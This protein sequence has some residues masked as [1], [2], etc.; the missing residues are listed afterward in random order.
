MSR[1][2][3]VGSSAEQ[4]EQYVTQHVDLPGRAVAAVDLHGAVRFGM[5]SAGRPDFVGR[6]VGLQPAEKVV[7]FGCATKVFVGSG[8]NRQAALQLAQ[9]APEC[10]Q[11]RVSGSVVTG[12]V[13]ARDSAVEV[14]QRSPEII[15][16]MGQPQMQVVVGGQRIQQFDVGTC[17]SGMA[18]Q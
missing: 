10:A 5:N 14:G 6:D 9:I 11:Q 4:A 16:G 12:V 3:R 15:A 2:S 7:G 17:Q 1:G 18:E 13:A 8:A